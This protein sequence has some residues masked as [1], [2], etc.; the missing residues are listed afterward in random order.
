M[1]NQ[2]IG[3]QIHEPTNNSSKIIEEINLKIKRT[4]SFRSPGLISVHVTQKIQ[5]LI[6]HL[7]DKLNVDKSQLDKD[8]ILYCVMMVMFSKYLLLGN[9]V[10]GRIITTLI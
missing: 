3:Y 8:A 2:N 7:L 1:L 5:N 6:N 10:F 9:P 4:S